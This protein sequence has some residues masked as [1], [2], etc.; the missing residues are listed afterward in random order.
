MNYISFK[1]S[2]QEL[3]NLKVFLEKIGFDKKKDEVWAVKLDKHLK[4]Y[5]V[6]NRFPLLFET[7]GMVFPTVFSAKLFEENFSVAKVDKG[8][9]SHIL[10]GAD[11]MAPGVT[12]FKGSNEIVLIEDEDGSVLAVGR[13]LEGF[14]E[15]LNKRHGKVAENMHHVNDKLYQ[16][17]VSKY[18]AGHP[19][20][21]YSG[22]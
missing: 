20:G 21:S 16:I 15:A 5:L 18:N 17:L 8:A 19:L 10:N 14:E 4:L 12:S 6:N 7:R 11:L 2:K 13:L 9:V 1:L 3:E 22:G